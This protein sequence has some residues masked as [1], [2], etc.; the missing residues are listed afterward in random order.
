MEVISTLK[1]SSKNVGVFIRVTD[2]FNKSVDLILKKSLV[3]SELK[4]KGYNIDKSVLGRFAY[5]LVCEH[6]ELLAK[7]PNLLLSASKIDSSS[8]L[9]S[10]FA[11]DLKK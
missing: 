3:I 10:S 9:L 4:A 6:L 5:L 2:E 1:D 8:E 7:N 11:R